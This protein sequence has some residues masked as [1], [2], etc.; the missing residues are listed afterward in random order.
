MSRSNIAAGFLDLATYDDLDRLLYGG[1]DSYSWFL[2]EVR[3]SSWFTLV[4]C[5][6]AR[7]TGQGSFGQ[8]WSAVVSRA[9]DYLVNTWLRVTIPAVTLRPDKGDNFRLRWTRNLLH[10]LVYLC[11]F[12]ANDLTLEQ[13]GSHFLDFWS[14]FTVPSSKRTAYSNCVG[15][16][17]E[18]IQ[19]HKPG[20]TIPSVA[21]N[22]P[23]PLFFTRDTGLSMPVCALPY[24][25]LRIGLQFRS[26]N[27]LLILDQIPDAGGAMCP[28]SQC[29]CAVSDLVE[30]EPQIRDATIWATYALVSAEE[31]QRLGC[32]PKDALIEQVQVSPT[33]TFSPL[34]SPQQ[35]VELRFS[36]PIKVLF[37]GIRNR[38]NPCEHSNYTAASPVPYDTCVD[39]SPPA[40]L[41]PISEASILYES[42]VR[43]QM[44]VDFFS[45]IQ[46][47][48]HSPSCPTE[49]GYHMYS[50][51]LDY[52]SCD[53]TGSSN[54]SRLSSVQLVLKASQAAIDAAEGGK[55]DPFSGA[56]CPQKYETVVLAVSWNLLRVASG[57]CGSNRSRFV[58]AISGPQ[59]SAD[60]QAVPIAC[61]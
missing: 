50:Y 57:S 36:H 15:N 17:S 21:L 7:A 54:Y 11:T 22:L 39:F 40:A 30:G 51:A 35:T 37:F 14:A 9:G 58:G 13:F 56:W 38:T 20:E 26:W 33:H 8:E 4:P 47:F 52:F 16:I 60:A 27:E 32:M 28:M 41:D 48:Y 53:P 1:A 29:V 46:P 43:V 18:L 10:N 49:T 25:E 2:R 31:R 23:L 44:P 45:L 5:A 59:Q 42:S 12:T 55:G 19:P 24:N 3:R 61:A 6:L 34:T